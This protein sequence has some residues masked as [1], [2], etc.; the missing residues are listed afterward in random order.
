MKA[1]NI[2]LEAGARP[3]IEATLIKRRMC[4][5]KRHWQGPVH[6]TINF[7]ATAASPAQRTSGSS[8]GRS[9]DR[10]VDRE[11]ESDNELPEVRDAVEEQTEASDEGTGGPGKSIED[12]ML[13]NIALT[14]IYK[15]VNRCPIVERWQ[16]GEITEFNFDKK[17]TEPTGTGE[18]VFVYRD[19]RWKKIAQGDELQIKIGYKYPDGSRE[20]EELLLAIV[21]EVSAEKNEI[22]VNFADSGVVLEQKKQLSYVDRPLGEVLRELARL[23]GL[24]LV[25]NLPQR[26]LRTRVTVTAETKSEPAVGG[27]GR[28]SGQFQNSCG[29]RDCPCPPS[30]SGRWIT[31]TATGPCICGGTTIVYNRCPP[32]CH[33]N[34]CPPGMTGD[35]RQGRG[36]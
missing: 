11:P 2:R 24:R 33:I 29:T 30:G 35:T 6:P 34:K 13:D 12:F 28:A 4:E 9:R 23:A 15:F 21:A 16:L 32:D 31:C 22:H 19:E 26:I 27:G 36:C 10:S 5:P 25:T 8:R 14:A 7:A 20:D 17:I 1:K 3:F 18:L